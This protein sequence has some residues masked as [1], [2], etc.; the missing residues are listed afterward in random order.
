MRVDLKTAKKTDGLTVLFA[1]LGSGVN[2]ISVKRTNFSY[3]RHFG[4]FFY[5]H[6]YVKKLPKKLLSYKKRARKTLMK[7]TEA[8]IKAA[9]K[10]LVKL[11]L[12]Q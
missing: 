1:L 12:D 2:F 10:M 9:N 5:V 3:E 8:R 4:S 7:L 11:A 6:T